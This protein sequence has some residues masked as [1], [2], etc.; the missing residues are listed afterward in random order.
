MAAANGKMGVGNL[1]VWCEGDVIT[2]QLL[3]YH[4]GQPFAL[5][6]VREIDSLIKVLKQ[7]QQKAKTLAA[8]DP[9]NDWEDLV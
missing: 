2:L 3:T 6:T 4:R 8:P 5:F 9:D 7:Y 1:A